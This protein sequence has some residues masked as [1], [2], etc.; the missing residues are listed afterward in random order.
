MHKELIDYINNPKS[1]QACF[2]LAEWYYKQNQWASALTYYLKVTEIDDNKDLTYFSLI[3]G[4][5]GLHKQGNQTY[6]AKGMYLQ[7]ISVLPNRTEAYN[8][9][10]KTYTEL[11]EWHEA[12][13]IAEIGMQ[14]ENSMTDVDLEYEGKV[15]LLITI[16][17]CY[18]NIDRIEEAINIYTSL[19]ESNQLD[20]NNRK[21]CQLMMNEI[22]GN[23]WIKPEYNKNYSQAFQDLFVLEVLEGKKNG[24]YLEIGACEPKIHS[25]TYL[26]ENDY[27]WTGISLEIDANLVNKFNGIRENKCVWGDAT[28]YDYDKL[29]NQL[30]F[31][32]VID[33]L[34][35]D[36]EPAKNTFSALLAIPFD[37]YK[38]RVITYEHDAYCDETTYRDKSRKYLTAMGYQ[39]VV[40]DVTYGNANNYFEDWWVHPELVNA[41]IIKKLQNIN[42]I[43]EYFLKNNNI[44]NYLC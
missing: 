33:Y 13:A 15:S 25:N 6:Q 37:K 24:K 43:N 35:L 8:W 29:L 26:L 7:A 9:L 40:S 27:N 20:E 4:G 38:F 2:N 21:W 12:M 36:I 23:G 17:N 44:E 1:S 42:D 32:A 11:K 18:R 5:R 10:S 34:Q 31:P 16:A 28:T 41:E 19:L 14:C 3:K 22:W 30:A 39:L